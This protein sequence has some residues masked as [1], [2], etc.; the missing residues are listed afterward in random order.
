MIYDIVALGE[1]LIDF[2]QWEAGGDRDG[3]ALFERNPG[4][5]PANLLAAA[6]ALGAQTAF[7]GKVGDDMHGRFLE[8]TLKRAGVST[9]GL[10][11]TQEAFT[12]MAFVAL[13][14]AALQG[15]L[16]SKTFLFIGFSNQQ[17]RCMISDNGTNEVHV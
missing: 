16:V 7:I 12:T 9:R 4:G 2:T 15:D 11:F 13:G 14:Y 6:A 3:E 1:L 8:E 5:A 17:T 10:A